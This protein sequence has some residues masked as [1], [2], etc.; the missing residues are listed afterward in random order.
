LAPPNG[1]RRLLWAVQHLRASP[2]AIVQD[3]E[4]RER[5][6]VPTLVPRRGE[7]RACH[8]LDAVDETCAVWE[9]APA[10]CA[11]FSACGDRP[12]TPDLRRRGLSLVLADWADGGPY[13]RLWQHLWAAGLRAEP[14]EFARAIYRDLRRLPPFDTAGPDRLMTPAERRAKREKGRRVVAAVRAAQVHDPE[15]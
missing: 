13:C 12:E 2:G 14:P 3:H 8:W 1:T 15:L 6:R 7:D 11:M 9:H 5:Y 10:G 4:T